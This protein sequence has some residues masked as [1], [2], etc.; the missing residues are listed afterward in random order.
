M[1]SSPEPKKGTEEPQQAEEEP[2]GEKT[3]ITSYLLRF[4]L[5][6]LIHLS[7]L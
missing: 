5:L 4:F 6:F 2:P 1:S 7:Q 3:N